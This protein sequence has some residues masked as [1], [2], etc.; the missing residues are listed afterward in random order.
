MFSK[1]IPTLLILTLVFGNLLPAPSASASIA[2][3][4]DWDAIGQTG[5]PTQGI[6]VQGNYAYIGVGPRL[7]VV[8]ISDPANPHQ[9]GASAMLDD[10][11]LGV[12]VSDTHVYVAAGG[13]G[14]QIFDITNPSTPTISGAWHSLGLAENVT[15][16]GDIAYV[17]N[18]PYGLRVLNVSNPATPVEIA[19]AF[20]MNYVDDVAIN[21]RY[22]Y[23]AAA[24]AGLLI[25]DIS[26]PGYP[27][28]LGGFDTPGY[29][30][31]V[32][33]S[34]SRAF[35]ADE[36]SGLQIINVA[37][38]LHPQLI[39]NIQTYGWAFDVTVSGDTA[40]LAAAFGGLRI[41][42]ISD[43]A[44]PQEV[45][46]L[47]WFQSNAIGL[48]RSGSQV[49]IA[50]Q[51]NGLRVINSA[52][53]V[54][55]QQTGVLN[56]F[57]LADMVVTDGNYAY[58]AA[59]YNGVRILDVQNITHP[60]EVSVFSI[61]GYAR[62]LEL[63]GDKLFMGTY[64][65]SPEW[66]VYVLD[67]SDPAHPVEISHGEWCG[68]C[69]EIDVVG[70][71]GYFAD[72]N[73]V[74]IVD[75]T[76]PANP[77][78]LGDTNSLAYNARTNSVTVKDD[79][80]Y[81]A[82]DN[83]ELRIYDV[84]D[85]SN[86]TIRGVFNDPLGFLGATVVLSGNYAYLNDWWGVRI[87]NVA[88]PTNPTE[89]AF[90]ATPMETTW[91][92]L[93]GDR[94]YVAQGSYG[95]E[96]LDV[97]DPANPVSL[98]SFDTPGAVLTVAVSNSSLFLADAEGGM[99]IYPIE[100]LALEKM[101]PIIAPPELDRAALQ[102]LAR[103]SHHPTLYPIA[104]PQTISNAPDRLAST[105]LVTS[106][107]DSG[108]G[109]LRQCLLNQVNGDVILFNP[110]VFPPANPQ[111]IYVQSQFQFLGVGNMT[112]DAS[113][114]GVILDGSQ[115]GISA[116]I[117]VGSD[118][119][120][121]RGLQIVGFNGTGIAVHGS[122]NLIGG[123]RLVG[124]GPIGQGNRLSE[125][126]L[127]MIVSGVGSEPPVHDNQILGNIVGLDATGTQP[128][129]NTAG[130]AFHSSQNNIVGSLQAGMN[131]I[132]S[133]NHQE[134]INLCSHISE[135]N[136][137]I[138][139]YIGT[140]ISGM[141]ALGNAGPAIWIE[142]G[143]TNTLVKGNLI[144]G[145][146]AG[147]VI[148]DHDSDFN[149]IIGNRIGVTAD[150]MQSLPNGSTA[151]GIGG[152]AYTRI[153]GT[154]PGEG[155]LIGTGEL[156][157]GGLLRGDTRI[158][159]NLVGLNAAGTAVLPPAGGIILSE[160]TRTI[161]GGATPAEANYII[162]DRHFSLDVRATQNTIIG[163][164]FGLGVDG[165]TPLTTANFQIL[166]LR[167]GN[168]FQG[169]H[170]AH[171]NS[172]GVWLEKAQSNTLRRNFIYN[173]NLGIGLGN[174]ANGL[175]LPPA[176]TLTSS[177]GS[178]TTCPHCTVELFLDAGNQGRYFLES[179]TADANG[180]FSFP[181]RCPLPYANLN[182]TTTDLLGNTSEF[183]A[184]HYGDPLPVPWDCDAPNPVPVLSALDPASVKEF[185]P[186]TL[187]TITG[188]NFIPGSVVQING[189]GMITLYANDSH[190]QAILPVGQITA[191]GTV[192]ITVFN[193]TPGGGTSNTL[194]LEILAHEVTDPT[195]LALSMAGEPDPVLPGDVLTYTLQVSNLGPSLATGVTL[196]DT[197]P[198]G[199][200]LDWAIPSQ[201]GCTGTTVIT[202]ELGEIYPYL[203]ASV[204]IRV[205]VKASTIGNL[206]NQAGVSALEPDP[207][208]NNNHAE[209]STPV[210]AQADLALSLSSWP[211]P[212]IAN[213]QELIYTLTVT[214]NGPVQATGVVLT[215][216][217]TADVTIVS[218]TSTQGTC[219]G[220]FPLTC[221]L[222]SLNPDAQA[223]VTITIIA[224][225]PGV[226]TNLAGVVA[227]EADPM[228]S[229]NQAQ[230]IVHVNSALFL[231]LILSGR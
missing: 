99:Q 137:F 51:K 182:A 47:S 178:G 36:R 91:L 80:A 58:V 62:V 93:S 75:F 79:L 203:G 162:T 55:P 128:A 90:Y 1:L 109:T 46:S 189:E 186:T 154:A 156:R 171:A 120:V 49:Y 17:A 206:F 78:F 85:P 86:L 142:C 150:G 224:N 136:Q 103:P 127:A 211:D 134:G 10:F 59:G 68:E 73:G 123:S 42:N 160:A 113:N 223:T 57:R 13:A 145:N 177:G 198:D 129:G 202:C 39:G 213:N 27:V 76:D 188:T 220:T 138:G 89:V 191:T 44:Y 97:G 92:A 48:A 20:E 88:D 18:G 118:G 102:P 225:R 214:N 40:Y 190:I 87:L 104:L 67:V 140:D 149:V 131:N 65:P 11:V 60:I 130:I 163:N 151:I 141:N 218:I 115:A 74:R 108:P 230:S 15:L 5:G 9:V 19:H 16:A 165:V 221:A 194:P 95:V 61:D 179:L 112:I 135:G 119:N 53:L 107:A 122:N 185:G 8:D 121:I 84:S 158:V 170:I 33:V 229:N 96:V 21:G 183:I 215:D 66:G 205:T 77:I 41:I 209:L 43:P 71:T 144:S 111:T 105:C 187:L 153:G 72:S 173:N 201:G 125:N 114:A 222:G 94:L 184:P 217:L 35:V 133:A 168:L 12:A 193:P 164:Y 24:G 124:N 81:V 100:S 155:N 126:L 181:A 226:L 166:S 54:H 117:G 28:E 52:D 38:P 50:D 176:I 29:A 23:I 34:G 152:P 69:A 37:D 180:A 70:N 25:A 143:A 167:D 200:T 174:G 207:D 2:P 139:N 195:D 228:P 212:V 98:G 197:L 7:V 82:L 31:A 175:L 219:G 216:M 26:N 22:A 4:T 199:A 32:A 208:P 159:G 172:M 64:G 231:P 204:K 147:I 101:D 196:T 227:N 6:A 169:N 157:V 132:I 110:T 83:A 161:V 146:G 3:S 148:W 14:L 45:G 192:S 63:A 56:P 210:N 106:T 116:G 30:Q